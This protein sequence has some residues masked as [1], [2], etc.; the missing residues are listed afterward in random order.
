MTEIDQETQPKS[1]ASEIV[2]N[3]GAMFV[4]ELRYGLDLDDDLL[5]ANEVRLVLLFSG[6]SL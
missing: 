5:E 4:G 1:R 3:L 2:V 6:R